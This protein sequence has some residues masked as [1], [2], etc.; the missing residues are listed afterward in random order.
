[1]TIPQSPA[2]FKNFRKNLLRW[3]AQNKRALPFRQNRD[4]YR[5][6]LSEIMA[7]QTTLAAVIPYFERFVQRFPTLQA[8]ADADEQELLTYW[9]G[10]GYYSR[11]R[12]FQKACQQIVQNLSGQMPTKYADLLALPGIGNYTAAAISSICHNEPVAVVD[13]NVKRVL[14]RLFWYDGDSQVSAAKVFFENKA[15][16]LLDQKNPGDFN[17]A[18]MELGALVCRPKSP[19]CL[20]CPVHNHCIGATQNAEILPIKKKVTFIDVAY[21]SLLWQ[22]KDC[23]LLKKPSEKN[24]IRN[25]W[26]LPSVYDG[27]QPHLHWQKDLQVSMQK[28]NLECV[29]AIQHG[30]TNKKITVH[31]FRTSTKDTKIKNND[32]V[33][34]PL[35]QLQGLPVNTISRKILSKLL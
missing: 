28:K 27:S 24:L 23:V 7:Q 13:G 16:M 29:D 8:V 35:Q 1:M 9:Q 25:M 32:Y 6:W 22:K 19:T 33:W 10:L 11:I 12:N 34:V 5:I 4:P 18:M 20:R 14:A 30:I 17:Q 26:E 2:Q 15:Q 31:V 21:S 3:Y